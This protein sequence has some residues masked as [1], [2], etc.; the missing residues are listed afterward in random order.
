MELV[1]IERDL[2]DRCVQRDPVALSD[3]YDRH[4]GHAYALALTLST[5]TAQANALI[6]RA[7]LTIWER[8]DRYRERPGQLEV[9]T[10]VLGLVRYYAKLAHHNDTKRS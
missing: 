8:A 10:W 6:E 4:V 9:R 7:F 5:D 3:L 2:I 1:E